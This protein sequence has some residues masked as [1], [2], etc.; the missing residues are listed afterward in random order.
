MKKKIF[1]TAQAMFVLLAAGVSGTHALTHTTEAEFDAGYPSILNPLSPTYISDTFGG[2][3][4]LNKGYTYTTG[5]DPAIGHDSVNHSW[6]DSTNNLLYVSTRGGGLSVID[7]KGTVDALDDTLAF[8]YTASSTPAI[9]HNSVSHSWLDSSTNLLYVSTFDFSSPYDSGLSVINLSTNTSFTYRSDGIYDT[10]TRTK[11]HDTPAIGHNRVWHSWLD[12]G[13]NRLYVGTWGG[14]LSIIDTN[15]TEEDPSDDTLVATY[16]TSSTPAI[17][18][19]YIENSF[20]NDSDPDNKLLYI[21]CQSGAPGCLSVINLNNNTSFTYR[22]TG[23]YNTTNDSTGTL[24]SSMPALGSNSVKHTFFDSV[25]NLLYVSHYNSPYG[26][27]VIDTKGTLD[28]ADDTVSTTYGVNTT[29]PIGGNGAYHS[30]LDSD[31]LLY[32][33]TNGGL[34][35]INTQGTA[36]PSDDTLVKTYTTSSNP[37]IGYNGVFHSWLDSGKNLLYVSTWGG[38]LSVV[39]Q[40]GYN[41]GG[42]YYSRA[43]L[44]STTPSEFISW[45]ETVSAGQ[46]VTLQTRT[47]DAGVFWV[48][49]FDDGDTGNISFTC[50][51]F[52]GVTESGGVVTFSDPSSSC[53][54]ISIDTGKTADYFPAG[55]IVRAR[56]KLSYTNLYPE[57][58]S[59]SVFHSWL[60]ST[61]NLLYISTRSGGLSVMNTQGTTDPSDDTLVISYTTDTTPALG[62]KNVNHSWLDSANNFLYVSSSW[63]GGG[64]LT[65]IDTKSTITPTD[66][67]LVTR[68]TISSTPAIGDDNVIHSWLDSNTDLLYISTF[69]G[70]LSVIDTQGTADPSDDT[71]VI[72]Y[73]TS[74]TPAIGHNRVYHSWLDTGTNRLYVGTWGGGLSIID[75]Q[76]TI[77]P[78]DDTLHKSYSTASTPAIGHDYIE[79]SFMDSPN[80]LLYISAQ[81]GYDYQSGTNKG[82][83]SVINLTTDTSF[84]YKDDGVYDTTN[85]STGTLISSAPAIGGNCVKHTFLDSANNLLYI[86]H[87]NSSYGVTVIDTK[88]TVDPADDT[89]SAT[90]GANTTPPIGGNGAY[91]SRLDSATGLYYVGTNGG[92]SVIDTQKTKVPADDTLVVTYNGPITAGDYLGTDGWEDWAGYSP[93]SINEWH[94]MT[95][96]ADESFSTIDLLP[97][98]SAHVDFFYEVDWVS[99]YPPEAGWGSWSVEYTDP[100]GSIITSDTTGMTYIQYR[101]NLST[102]DTGDTPAVNSVTLGYAP[103][104]TPTQTPTMTPTSTPTPT[105]TPTQTPTPTITP[106]PT[107]TPTPT[108]TPTVTSTPTITPTPFGVLS[109]NFQPPPPCE[110][111]DGYIPDHGEQFDY[112]Y[113]HQYGW[114]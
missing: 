112:R 46:D 85:D 18:H 16:T 17:G 44:L 59:N 103:T 28:P 2:E 4:I 23:V 67:T 56:A 33:G 60:D 91:H 37:A 12:S 21:S 30:W 20:I 73:T 76:G 104:P 97:H 10:S 38:G 15:G 102:S 81:S 8:A 68:Y 65:V 77:D 47:G 48:D 52:G 84:T 66:D 51:S 88:G 50:N 22:N 95:L 11:I 114:K 107:T 39:P 31:G 79:N 75:T 80:N 106:T 7:T 58:G 78:S 19:D 71:L 24:I 86:S 70:G 32:I 108:I 45:D 63:D 53:V 100:S 101:V 98:V 27:T 74:T 93:T 25:N 113:S 61:S 14:G 35:I 82:C 111:P 1:I 54:C 13:T 36:D 34:S 83:L 62:N 9:W 3:I 64:G 87:Y 90:Y 105:Q 40:N 41:P 6:L 72:T 29:T 109:V 43:L 55:S 69:G 92:F 26:V 94:T 42:E 89:V 49:E 110:I 96:V 5:T 99:V 57:I